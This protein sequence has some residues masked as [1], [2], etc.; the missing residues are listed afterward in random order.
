MYLL[1]PTFSV[2]NIWQ[3]SVVCR[4]LSQLD[5]YGYDAVEG[6]AILDSIFDNGDGVWL[7]ADAANQSCA[8]RKELVVYAPGGLVCIL[9]FDCNKW[10]AIK[11]YTER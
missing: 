3:W 7:Y 2:W 9:F 10:R 6:D 5:Q 4:W 8:E 11:T 1:V